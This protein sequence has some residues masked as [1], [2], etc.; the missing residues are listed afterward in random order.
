MSE[1]LARRLAELDA[2]PHPA[3]VR[4]DGGAAFEGAVP[5]LPSAFNPPTL[6]HQHLLERALAFTGASQAIALLT[7]RNVDKALHGASLAHRIG[8]LLAVRQDWRP[9]AVVASNQARIVDQ[10]RALA[11]A[12]PGREFDFVVGFDTLE[13]LF[14]PRYYT[15]MT[16]E[17]AP[18]FAKHRVLAANRGSV[19]AEHVGEWI[20]ANSGPFLERVTVLEIDEFPASLSSTQVRQALAQDDG[21][22]VHI[23]PGVRRY[24]S[25]HRLYRE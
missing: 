12:F 9:L 15:D 6:A 11:L 3:V 1:P 18:F 19:Q 24:I 22:G 20:A 10:A 21:D 14:A 23:A 7:T 17:L 4:F 5:V 13:R 25:R 16:A 8:M 2:L